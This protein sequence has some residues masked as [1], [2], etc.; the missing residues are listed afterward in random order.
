MVDST[1]WKEKRKERKKHVNKRQNVSDSLFSHETHGACVADI[2]QNR[3]KSTSKNQ[4]KQ[5][6]SRPR[7]SRSKMKKT[8]SKARFRRYFRIASARMIQMHCVHLNRSKI[9]FYP[10][11]PSWHS[12]SSFLLNPFFLRVQ[13]ASM[14]WYVFVGFVCRFARS[15]QKTNKQYVRYSKVKKS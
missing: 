7:P 11:S 10:R 15:D 9:F 6:K 12:Q 4:S 14:V 8:K 1:K 13:K 5:Q 2:K 3:R